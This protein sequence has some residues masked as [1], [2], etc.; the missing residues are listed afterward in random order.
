[1]ILQSDAQTPLY[2]QLKETVRARIVRGEYP[3]GA[4]IPSETELRV[5]FGVS[6]ITVRNAI[7]QLV[8]E[9]YLSKTQ[10]KGTFVRARKLRRKLEYV[11]GFT[12]SLRQVGLDA[13]TTVLQ[14]TVVE[15]TA[16]VAEQLELPVGAPVVYL[17]RIRS[18]DGQP[19]CLEHSYFDAGRY[20]LLGTED[21]TGSLYALLAHRFGVQVAGEGETILEA[22]VADPGLAQTMSGH[23]GDPYFLMTWL[24]KDQHDAPLHVGIDYFLGSFFTFSLNSSR[25]NGP[26]RHEP[27]S[28]PDRGSQRRGGTLPAHS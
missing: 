17:Q 25:K 22:V 20:H 6:R 24:A 27:A 11:R 7:E 8:A 14:N 10:G 9:G 21:L 5:E 3:V 1:M 2:V 16:Q 23:I 18:V 26:V 12:E 13:S 19:V 15:A 28:P 4:K